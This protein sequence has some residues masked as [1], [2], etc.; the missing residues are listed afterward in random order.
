V[1]LL[2]GAAELKVAAAEAGVDAVETREDKIM[3]GAAGQLYQVQGRFPRLTKTR[4]EG[5][6]AEI[7]KLLESLPGSR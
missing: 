7:R 3:L 4:P 6:L 1:D 2:L 5:K